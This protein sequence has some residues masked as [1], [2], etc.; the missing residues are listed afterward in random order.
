MKT[1]LKFLDAEGKVTTQDK[2]VMA[3]ETVLDESGKVVKSTI[4]VKKATGEN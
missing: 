2:G 3:R 4:F 1:L